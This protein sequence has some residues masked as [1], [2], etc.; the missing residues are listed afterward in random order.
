MRLN[1][2][3]PSR[4][5]D[6]SRS[7]V[8]FWGYDSAIEVSFFVESGALQRLCPEMSGAETGL[9]EAF[10]AARSRIH[11]VADKVYVRG[12]KG[13]CAYSLVAEDF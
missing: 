7:R 5:F 11:E 6:A 2:P 10:D 4:S 9:L 12:G 8:C 1:F 13:V 3:N